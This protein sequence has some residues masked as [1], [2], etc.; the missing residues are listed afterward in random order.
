MKNRWTLGNQSCND[1]GQ[2]DGRVDALIEGCDVYGALSR[3][4]VDD[5]GNVIGPEFRILDTEPAQRACAQFS[6]HS[7]RVCCTRE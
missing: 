1:Y 6:T 5:G 7:V 3:W 4:P 2:Q